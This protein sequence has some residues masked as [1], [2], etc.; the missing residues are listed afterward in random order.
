MK[1]DNL[2]KP[3][4]RPKGSK[5]SRKRKQRP[6]PKCDN[7][8]G[9]KFGRWLVNSIA[10]SKPKL[11][12]VYLNVTCDCG[13]NKNIQSEG[14][15]NNKSTSCGCLHKEEMIKRQIKPNN[16]AAKKRVFNTYKFG[17]KYRKINFELT[18]EFLFNIIQQNCFYCDKQP[19][20]TKKTTIIEFKYNGIDRVD[21]DVGY[22][23]SNCV[24]C[25][26]SCNFSKKSVNK[27]I[28]FKAYEFLYKK[29]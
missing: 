4:G 17:A 25:C 26:D 1:N 19:S 22:I 20:N 2:K 16:Y 10:F 11:R 18:E 23:N 21:N 9:K 14:L 5:D 12:R 13:T 29:Q 6:Y 15:V 8:I 24:P 7:L 28:I 3:I 27:N